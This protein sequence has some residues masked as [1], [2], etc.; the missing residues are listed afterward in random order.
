MRWNDRIGR[1]IKLRDLHVLQ[2]R[3][4]MRA[5]WRRRRASLPSPIRSSRTDRELEHT[6]GVRLLDET[7]RG[8]S[9]RPGRAILNRSHAAF[10]ELRQ[11]IKDI[12]FLAD[13]T[14][15]EV[16]IGTTPPLAAS[17][18]SAVV[19]RLAKRYPRIMFHVMV[20][21]DDVQRRI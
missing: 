3:R 2:R 1:R 5:A 13:P 14:A 16:R 19:D 9:P 12:E 11:G 18:V 17:F 15:G 4:A 21:E 20:E 6:L 7:P 10:D 8:S